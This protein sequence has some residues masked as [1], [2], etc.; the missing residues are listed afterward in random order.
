MNQRENQ[1]EQTDFLLIG[2]LAIGLLLTGCTQAPQAGTTAA[3]TLPPTTTYKAMPTPAQYPSG[4]G[5]SGKYYQV[6][7]SPEQI[8]P[9]SLNISAGDTV[10]FV[11][12]N[13]YATKK[14]EFDDG[15]P[16]IMLRFQ[17]R[18]NR[19]FSTTGR[20]TY[21]DANTQEKAEINV[22]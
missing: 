5:T 13:R 19:T 11:N 8:F 16:S 17:Q 6:Q 20:Y 15:F 10:I 1:M 4:P 22:S 2:V 21:H 18:A 3:T 14:L 7:I 9:P 12:M